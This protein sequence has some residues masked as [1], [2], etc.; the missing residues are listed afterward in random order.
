LGI[1]DLEAVAAAGPY[2][3]GCCSAACST[4][5]ESQ[6]CFV[7]TVITVLAMVLLALYAIL[8]LTY[9]QP[10][11]SVHLT[12]YDDIHPG[13]AA[14]LVSPSFNI[15][16]RMNHTCIDSADLAVTYSGVA[17]GA[18]GLRGRAA[19][20]EGPRGRGMGRHGDA[21][22]GLSWSLRSRMASDWRSSGTVELDV[23]VKMYPEGRHSDTDIPH[24]M[25]L[26]KVK[27]MKKL[28]KV[29]I[30]DEKGENLPTFSTSIRW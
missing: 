20:G 23:D 22:W 15:T 18:A 6:G 7:L 2:C 9:R 1:I 29:K 27:I 16:L 12:G 24:H 4:I 19:L 10:S 28:Q 25:I 26:E 21:G 3:H 11:F 8:T 30:V 5:S 14:G 17:R 13:R